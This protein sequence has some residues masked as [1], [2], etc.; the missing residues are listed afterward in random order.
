MKMQYML[1]N[2]L[3]IVYIGNIRGGVIKYRYYNIL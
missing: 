2:V 1:E 3:R